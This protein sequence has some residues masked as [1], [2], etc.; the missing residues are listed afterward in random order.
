MVSGDP[1]SLPTPPDS[2]PPQPSRPAPPDSEPPQPSRPAPPNSE[3]PQPSR[4]APPDSEPPQPS[5]DSAE[6]E[7][8]PTLPELLRLKIPQKVG[9]NYKIFG[10]FLLNDMMGNRVTSIEL[11]SLGK[12]ESILWEILRE[13]VGGRGAV[14]TWDTLVKILRDCELE[15]LAREVL[16]S[17]LPHAT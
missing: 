12:P 11:A 15:V 3:P 8:R 13:W 16:V 14:P 6:T 10:T 5:Q 1:P 9:P 2:E 7:E 17:K 4:P